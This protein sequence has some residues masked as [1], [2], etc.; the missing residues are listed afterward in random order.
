MKT[1]CQY[2]NDVVRQEK[3][4]TSPKKIIFFQ[5]KVPRLR[6]RS[7]MVFPYHVTVK[8]QSAFL[9]A[10]LFSSAIAVNPSLF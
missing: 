5:F 2:I 1:P 7:T 9:F 10:S 6:L 8:L 3:T 4:L